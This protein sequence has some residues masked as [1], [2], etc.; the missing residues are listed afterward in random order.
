VRW[1][2]LPRD[3]LIGAVR[4]YRLFFSAWLGAGCRYEPTC[5]V[6]ALHA[7]QRHGALAGAGLAA[8]RVLRCHPG[9]AGGLDPVPQ[10]RPR[11]FRHLC[12]GA[13]RDAAAAER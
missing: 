3:G 10:Q 1:Q 7:L 5:S 11:L 6:Y 4:G 9:C 8:W 13:T 2:D 12:A